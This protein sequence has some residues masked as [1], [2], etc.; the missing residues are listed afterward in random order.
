MDKSSCVSNVILDKNGEEVR[1]SFFNEPYYL[2]KPYIN[3]ELKD[4]SKVV[5]VQYKRKFCFMKLLNK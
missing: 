5:Y 1:T 4:G 2:L 3:V